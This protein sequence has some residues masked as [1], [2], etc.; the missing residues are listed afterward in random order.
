M[1]ETCLEGVCDRSIRERLFWD[2]LIR[3]RSSWDRSSQDRSSYESFTQ[4]R[5]IKD[6]F[7]WDK[8]S[9]NSQDHPCIKG[10]SAEYLSPRV[11]FD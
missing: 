5:A 6:R 1:S 4:D 7:S 11:F 2:R 8:L 9:W 10:K 3:D